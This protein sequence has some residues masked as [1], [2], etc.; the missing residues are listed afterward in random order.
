MHKFTLTILAFAT[1]FIF[2]G[3]ANGGAGASRFQKCKPVNESCFENKEKFYA[4]PQ[5]RAIGSWEGRRV[6]ELIS[7]WGFPDRVDDAT[8]GKPGKRYVWIEEYAERMPSR[9]YSFGWWWWYDWR[10]AHEPYERLRC[11]TYMIVAPDGTLTPAWVDKFGTC[12]R[13]FNPR[14]S[15]PDA[16]STA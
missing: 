15:A 2:A 10:F 9:G 7:E 12:T 14:P 1:L 5:I 4:Q 13:H 11:E 6:N 3:C 8:D 16:D